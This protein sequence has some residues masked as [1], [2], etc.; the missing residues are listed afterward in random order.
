[1]NLFLI[2]KIGIRVVIGIFW[3]IIIFSFL[4]IPRVGKLFKHRDS[5]SIFSFP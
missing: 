1:M 3:G 2:H 4:F 5:L